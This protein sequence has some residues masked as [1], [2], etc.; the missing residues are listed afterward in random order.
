MFGRPNFNFKINFRVGSFT[1]NQSFSAWANNQ[2]AKILKEAERRMFRAAGFCRTD[3]RRGFPRKRKAIQNYKG[4]H[5]KSHPPSGAGKPPRRRATGRAGLQFVTFKQD[6]RFEFRI[7]SDT[8]TKW[9]A[10]TKF[11]GDIKHMTGG[12]GQVMLPMELEQIPPSMRGS[13][14]N[15]TRQWPMVW[16]NCHYKKRDYLT[17]SRDKTHKQFPQL[18]ANLNVKGS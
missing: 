14:L 2:N 7:G 17:P 5:W 9:G 1:G 13:A 15:Q 12:Q 10:K 8:N 16:K 6:S 3:I 4:F 11:D 18:F